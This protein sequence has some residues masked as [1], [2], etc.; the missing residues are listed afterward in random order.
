[1]KKEKFLKM[2][3]S[4]NEKIAEL[5]MGVSI[6]PEHPQLATKNNTPILEEGGAANG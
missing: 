1:M 2:K 3:T 5:L 4:S 6:G